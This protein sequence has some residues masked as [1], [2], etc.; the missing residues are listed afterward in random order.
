[1]KALAK[2]LAPVT[3][4]DFLQKHWERSHLLVRGSTDKLNG[5]PTLASID[6]MICE[7]GVGRP[8][9]TPYDQESLEQVYE[10]GATP[11]QLAPEPLAASEF[12]CERGKIV[13]NAAH[14]YSEPLARLRA[15]LAR[16]LGMAAQI[17]VYLAAPHGRGAEPHYDPHDVI[18]I[19]LAGKKHWRLWR[20]PLPL[21]ARLPLDRHAE[22]MKLG[23]EA[24][25]S[26]PPLAELTLSAGDV[27]YFPRGTLHAVEPDGASSLHLTIGLAPLRLGA[28]W[29]SALRRRLDQM[30]K[31]PSMRRHL[32][33]PASRIAR[34][35]ESEQSE[36]ARAADRVLAFAATAGD[37]A[38]AAMRERPSLASVR[39]Q[40]RR[41]VEER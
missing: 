19:H 8:F 22:A 10:R 1:M 33:P 18:V 30:R 15:E 39:G 26:R 14:R 11:L 37:A 6:R 41:A 25:L 23:I 12:F 5:L 36:S 28:A 31:D 20:A 24:T 17:N 35:L 34:H 4:D 16:E 13:L 2:I 7:N 40:W 9:I 3:A 38:A 21:P 32:A 27:L 29:A